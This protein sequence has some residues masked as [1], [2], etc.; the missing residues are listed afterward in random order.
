MRGVISPVSGGWVKDEGLVGRKGQAIVEDWSSS[1]SF[2]CA[3]RD[4][5]ARGSAQD[6]NVLRGFAS[7]PSQ[8]AR[9]M[10]HPAKQDKYGD[11]GY[12][13]MTTLVATP[14]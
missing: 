13:R 12:A 4:E 1:G 10:G 5:T 11:S 14:E 3:S 8:R 9:W 7:H 2:D 6:D